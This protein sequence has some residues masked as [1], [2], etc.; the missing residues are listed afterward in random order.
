MIVVAGSDAA[1]GNGD[2]MRVAPEIGEDLRRAAERLLGIDDPI[3]APRGGQMS[4]EGSGIGQMCEIAEEAETPGAEGGLQAFEKRRRNSRE[5]GLTAR[6]KLAR[7][8]IHRA[9]S[10]ESTPPGMTQWT[11]G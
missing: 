11:C 8:S 3:D 5:S 9:L 4:G 1:V 6:K 2:A 10:S 7:P